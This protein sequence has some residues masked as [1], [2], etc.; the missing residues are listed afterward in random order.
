MLDATSIF[1]KQII[2]IDRKPGTIEDEKEF[3]WMI[4]VAQEELK[5]LKDAHE[6]GDFIKELDAV[7][8]LVYFVAGFFTRYGIDPSTAEKIFFAV[9]DCNMEKKKGMKNRLI[10]HSNDAVKPEGWVGPEERIMEILDGLKN[11][12]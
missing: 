1:N 3:N 9:H 6:E 5:E 12:R 8:D 7:T 2:G 11:L 4:G 10:K